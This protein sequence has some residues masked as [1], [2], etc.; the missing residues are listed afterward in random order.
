MRDCFIKSFK[1]PAVIEHEKE[2][3]IEAQVKGF[4]E[5]VIEDI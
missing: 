3:F 5:P 1:D 2:I 4:P